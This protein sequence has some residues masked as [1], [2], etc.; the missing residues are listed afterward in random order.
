[1]PESVVD[2]LRPVL[3]GVSGNAALR[4]PGPQLVG[5][6]RPELVLLERLDERDTAPRCLQ[7][8]LV[9][10]NWTTVVPSTSRATSSSISSILAIVSV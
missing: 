8:E 9:S 2:Q 7:V 4:E 10:L 5:I 3:V 6:A 1:M